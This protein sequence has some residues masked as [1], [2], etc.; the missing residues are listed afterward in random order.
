MKK[1]SFL[2]LG[3]KVNQY[4]TEAMIELFKEKKYD[5]VDFNEVSDIYVINTCTVTNLSARKSRQF[6]SKAKKNNPNAIIAVLGCYS[7]TSPTE[8]EQIE[9]VDVIIGTDSKNNI[10]NL[11]EKAYISNKTINIVKKDISKNFEDMSINN[12]TGMTRAYIKIQDGCNQFCSYCIIPFAR[13]RIRSRKLDSIYTEAMRLGAAGYKEIVLTGIHVASYGLDFE[14]EQI[15]L[16]DAI[17]TVAKVDKIKRI[18]LSS[19]EPR[20]ITKE[21]LDEIIKIDK[22]CDHFHMSLQSGSDR[23]LKLMN[24]KYDTKVYREKVELLKQYFPNVGITTDIIVGFPGE[25]EKDFKNTCDFVKEIGFSKI[26]VFKYSPRKGTKAAKMPQ[27]N[28]KTKKERSSKLIA[29]SE[30]LT[31]EFIDN[32]FNNNLEVLFEEKNENNKLHGYSKNYIRVEIDYDDK[33]LN[34]IISVKAIDRNNELLIGRV[35]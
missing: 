15:S 14:D 22:V 21:F 3:C 32:Q 35:F 23:V 17:K 4:E 2:T 28:G 18:R 9:G 29:I 8:V 26:H 6:I 31:D 10:V 7:Q 11:C 1:V 13:G 20:I 30:E 12:Q 24:R 19:I 16:I 33:L 25:T 5:I 27:I 34:E